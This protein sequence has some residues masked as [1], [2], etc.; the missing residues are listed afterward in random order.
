[1]ICLIAAEGQ[2]RKKETQKL[3]IVSIN[4]GT[5]TTT[6]EISDSLFLEADWKL[7][8]TYQWGNPK[9]PQ[10]P[11]HGQAE[12]DKLILWLTKNNTATLSIWPPT[13]P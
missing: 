2:Q 3:K 13:M 7:V 10:Q 6:T 4:P 9:Q 12:Q 1:M 8:Y 11:W 5:S